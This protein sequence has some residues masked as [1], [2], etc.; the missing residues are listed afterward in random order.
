LSTKQEALEPIDGQAILF[1]GNKKTRL[2]LSLASQIRQVIH[3]SHESCPGLLMWRW[4]LPSLFVSATMPG[5]TVG[6]MA[7]FIVEVEPFL[8]KRSNPISVDTPLDFFVSS[9][10][11]WFS[12]STEDKKPGGQFF[13]GVDGTW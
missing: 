4:S 6:L 11:A 9:H 8:S 1:G 13:G 12:V 7:G 5:R 3:W 2:H 10:S